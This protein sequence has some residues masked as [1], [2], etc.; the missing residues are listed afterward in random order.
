MSLEKNGPLPFMK[1]LGDAVAVCE[2]EHDNF[3]VTAFMIGAWLDLA[4][5]KLAAAYGWPA[6]LIDEQIL[7]RLLKLNLEYAF[8]ETH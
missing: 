4:H 5:K 2:K 7:E 3:Y 1:S 8:P 6:D